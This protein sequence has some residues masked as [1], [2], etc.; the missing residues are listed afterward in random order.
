MSS[1]F[2]E[3]YIYTKNLYNKRCSKKLSEIKICYKETDN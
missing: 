3:I 2:S 1:V